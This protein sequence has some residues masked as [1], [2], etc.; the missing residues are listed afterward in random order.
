MTPF[1][2]CNFKYTEG[3]VYIIIYVLINNI[4][5]HEWKK[6][7]SNQFRDSQGRWGGSHMYH[8]MTNQGIRWQCSKWKATAAHKITS[9]FFLLLFFSCILFLWYFYFILLPFSF[10]ERHDVFE[11]STFANIMNETIGRVFTVENECHRK[12]ST[13]VKFTSI[14]YCIFTREIMKFNYK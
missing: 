4:Y 12:F 14:Y 3:N 10:T 2:R 8:A 1:S 7:K 13:Y 11:V 5:L 6:I 9:T